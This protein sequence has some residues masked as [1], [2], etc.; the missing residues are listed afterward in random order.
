[1]TSKRG[2]LT[3]LHFIEWRL[4]IIVVGVAISGFPSA[5]S[6]SEYTVKGSVNSLTFDIDG[7]PRKTEIASGI[8]PHL[9]C[10]FI[11]YRKAEKWRL[12]INQPDPAFPAGVWKTIMPFGDSNLVS[13]IQYPPRP[14]DSKSKGNAFVTV[15]TNKFL[16]AQHIYGAHAI[17][18]TLNL[19][20]ALG[21]FG[22]SGECPP[23]WDYDPAIHS[24][25]VKS[26]QIVRTNGMILFRNPGHYFARDR[27]MNLKYVDG[28]PEMLPLPA[29]LQLGYNEAEFE[30]SGE[31]FDEQ[32][33]LAKSAELKYWTPLKDETMPNGVRMA[34]LSK[35]VVEIKSVDLVPI[36]DAIF[37]PV[38]TN[39]FAAIIDNRERMA[40]RAQPLNYV[41]KDKQLNPSTADLHKRREFSEK[42][43]KSATTSPASP[44]RLF[45]IILLICTTIIPAAVWL[46]IRCRSKLDSNDMNK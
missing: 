43:A 44:K 14:N 22:E 3:T 41:T 32:L 25:P 23:F 8:P 5:L 28:K 35:L 34:M 30:M 15:M 42:L 10:D 9:T 20:E 21:M 46:T 17:W 18:L 1:M 16:P 40:D 36:P 2:N 37:S 13:I 11:W 45:V 12:E 24:L 19:N 4:L 33:G 7:S 39:S 27:G 29:P 26:H 31:F 38:W 6:A